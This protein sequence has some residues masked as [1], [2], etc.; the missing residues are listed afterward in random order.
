MVRF[1]ATAILHVPLLQ[2]EPVPTPDFPSG[3]PRGQFALICRARDR[4]CALPLSQVVETMRPLPVETLAA[5][6]T[7]VSGLS[8]ARGNPVAVVDLGAMLGS[9]IPAQPARFVMVRVEERRV[10]LAVEEVLGIR[11]LS[12]ADTVELPPLLGEGAES[13]VAAVGVLDAALLVVLRGARLVPA[14][15]WELLASARAR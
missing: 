5:M 1:G 13:Q 4:L 10:L 2:M 12:P 3:L 11:A 15:T 9:N 6:P 14:S 8:R 7:F